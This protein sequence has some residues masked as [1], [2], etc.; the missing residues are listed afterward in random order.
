[1]LAHFPLALHERSV[2]ALQ[3]YSPLVQSSHS[4][5]CSSQSA[6]EPQVWTRVHPVPVALHCCSCAPSGAVG[7]VLEAQR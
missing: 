6:A 5:F 7:V 3:L 1:V 4:W 2:P